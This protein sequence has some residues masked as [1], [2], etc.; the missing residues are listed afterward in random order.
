MAPLLPRLWC[1]NL[2]ADLL[3]QLP[4]CFPWLSHGKIY[5]TVENSLSHSQ[6]IPPLGNTSAVT[7]HTSRSQNIY[8]A[9]MRWLSV[10]HKDRRLIPLPSRW[11]CPQTT[12]TTR[13]SYLTSLWSGAGPHFVLAAP[14]HSYLSWRT[15]SQRDHGVKFR[16]C[17][18]T[19]YLRYVFFFQVNASGLMINVTITR[20]LQSK[21]HRRQPIPVLGSSTNTSRGGSGPSMSRPPIA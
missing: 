15:Q 5:L 11:F 14:T 4:P 20:T 8:F 7:H 21:L 2:S 17:S 6:R 18:F 19:K 12:T 9:G 13:S 1:S 3:I 10:A 16:V